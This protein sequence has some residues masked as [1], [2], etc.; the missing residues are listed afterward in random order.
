VAFLVNVA[1]IVLGLA[2]KLLDIYRC[3]V[4]GSRLR[5]NKMLNGS[6]GTR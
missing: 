1:E 5:V 4:E 6:G 3:E 2:S